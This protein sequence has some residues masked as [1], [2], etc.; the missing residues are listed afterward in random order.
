MSERDSDPKTNSEE[1][2]ISSE[3]TAR[4]A[5]LKPKEEIRV[6][7][8]LDTSSVQSASGR[9]S[10]EERQAI[11]KAIQGVAE[12]GLGDIDKI[13]EDCGGQRLAEPNALGFILVET[14]AAGIEKLV[15]SE[16]VKSIL[17]DQEVFLTK[18][19]K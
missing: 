2:K 14:T 12:Q 1:I 15:E 6:V 3:F 11:L 7:V 16:R 8:R 9:P 17:E 5:G 4:V 19:V 18:G 10:P 13:L